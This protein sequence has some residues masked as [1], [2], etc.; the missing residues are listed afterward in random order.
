MMGTRQ[1]GLPELRIAD[2]MRDSGLLPKVHSAAG[3]LLNDYPDRVP[4]L[5]QRWLGPATRYTKV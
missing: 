2:L 3:I 1:T 4:A 5:I